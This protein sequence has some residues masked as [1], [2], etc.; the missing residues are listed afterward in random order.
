MALITVEGS[1]A[2]WISRITTTND[3][4][5]C[6]AVSFWR[7]AQPNQ[8]SQTLEFFVMTLESTAQT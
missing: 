3:G 6:A 5:Q 4:H 7:E 8:G 2:V 1:L